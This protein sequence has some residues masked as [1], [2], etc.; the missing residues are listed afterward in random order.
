MGGLLRD[1]LLRKVFPLPWI[2]FFF[3]VKLDSNVSTDN[4]L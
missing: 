3:L 4:C 2:F 1:I